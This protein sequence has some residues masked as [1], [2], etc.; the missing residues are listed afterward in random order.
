M[1]EQLMSTVQKI[2]SPEKD[3]SHLPWLYYMIMLNESIARIAGLMTNKICTSLALISFFSV[4]GRRLA[5]FSYMKGYSQFTR[6]DL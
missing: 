1:T 2:R 3:R 5:S 4:S 6:P